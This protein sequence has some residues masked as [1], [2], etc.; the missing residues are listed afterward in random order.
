[1]TAQ[2]DTRS[3]KSLFRNVSFLLM[4][5]SVAASGFGDR[6]MMLAALTL[7]GATAGSI[8]GTSVNA[9]LIFWFFLPYLV[10]GVPAGWLA[11]KLPRKWIM[12]ACDESR[13][14][15]LLLAFV[16]V[17][18]TGVAMIDAEDHWRVFALIACGGVFAAVFNPARNATIPQ[19][20]PLNHLQAANALIL[21]IA[22]I[23]SLIGTLAGK[24]LIDPEEARSV[25][26]G[27]L[28]GFLFFAISGTFFAF[29]KVH[30]RA[31]APGH[32][33]GRVSLALP[34][35]LA[36]RKVLALVVMNMVVW[37]AAFVVYNAAMGLCKQQYGFTDQKV[38]FDRFLYMTVA[39][40][41]GMLC[42]AIWVAWMNTRR[43][44]IGIAMV[45]LLIAAGCT[46]YLSLTH[47]Y[48]MALPLAFGVGFFGN[49]TIICVTTL[50]QGISPNYM[51][52]RVMGFNTLANTTSNVAINLIIWRMPDADNVI[53]NILRILAWVLAAVALTGLWVDMTRGP[54]PTRLANV[55][56]RIGRAYTLV[57]HR[58]RF[59]NKH[60]V[61]ATGPVILCPN[62]TTAVD[63]FLIQAGS[64]RLVRWLMLRA[65]Q[66][67]ILAPLWWAIQPIAL[68]EAGGHLARVRQLVRTLDEG[69]AVGLFPEGR[70]Q[71]DSRDLGEF[72][73][74]VAMIAQ[75][76]GAPIVPVWIEG[77]PRTK[78][79]LWHFLKPSRSVVVFGEPYTPSADWSH[80]QVLDD[81]RRRMVALRDQT[82]SS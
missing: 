14:L 69:D 23:A 56:W 17:P 67:R 33:R 78:H 52:G 66:F 39:I 29:L 61:P 3:A 28:V 25:R 51:R 34:Y 54:M 16:L 19:I 73:P 48:A 63:P 47:S 43:E 40:G 9:G 6:V 7:L 24:V 42:G 65:F 36:H 15:V 4:W 53:I 41:C 55:L 64:R 60:N 50:L 62:H 74:G 57:W 44:S 32:V 71:R 68:D 75:R 76:S 8:Q 10:L 58:V 81:L 2:P 1:M 13:G 18:T 12:L 70:L 46:G 20:V 27:L 79:M 45:A 31:R 35:V 26:H 30:D 59:V 82:S 21:G 72:H 22:V 38:I 11:V 37:G 80:E 49:T 77:T 5:S